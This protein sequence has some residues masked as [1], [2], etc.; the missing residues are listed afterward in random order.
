MVDFAR[1]RGLGPHHLR[2]IRWQAPIENLLEMLPAARV[3]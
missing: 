1:G 2:A 3:A